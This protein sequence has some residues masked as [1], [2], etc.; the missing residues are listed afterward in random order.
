MDGTH[1]L[2][3]QCHFHCLLLACV[4]PEHS[5]EDQGAYEG[6]AD[7]L[8]G[9]GVCFQGIQ[10]P[11]TPRHTQSYFSFPF[12]GSIS[13]VPPAVIRPSAWSLGS[14]P[15]SC[16]GNSGNGF[17]TVKQHRAPLIH[18]PAYE[19]PLSKWIWECNLWF[20]F[21][22]DVQIFKKPIIVLRHHQ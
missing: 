13:I 18:C 21:L 7:G 2:N 3:H 5:E 6:G 16:W 14:H 10:S 11:T 9:P 4:F 22:Q 1:G 15:F 17:S 20:T 8:Q 12:Q 19:L